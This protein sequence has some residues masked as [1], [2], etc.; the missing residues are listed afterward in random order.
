LPELTPEIGIAA[1]AVARFVPAWKAARID[2][3]CALRQE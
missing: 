2:P 3:G 1:A